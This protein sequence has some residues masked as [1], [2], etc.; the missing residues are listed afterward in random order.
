MLHEVIYSWTETSM[1]GKKMLAFGPVPSRRLGRSLGVNNVPFKTCSYSCI[2]CQLG[3]TEKI[4]KRRSFYDPEDLFS[5]VSERMQ[6]ARKMGERIDYATFVPDG[7]PTLDVNI[8]EEISLIR[9]T[10]VPVA[11]IT[12]A[13][14]LWLD[15][16]RQDL[17]NAD[18][19]CFKL[20]AVSE[21]AWRRVNRPCQKLRLDMIL[22]GI[23]RF[24]EVFKGKLLSET[25]I[26]EG[27][28]CGRYFRRMAAFLSRL[29][30]L[31]KAYV[32][33]PTRPPA[34]KW[35]RPASEEV[36]NNAFQVF[37][38]ELG[39]GRVECLMDYEGHTFSHTG[40]VRTDLLGI[41]SVHPMRLE[42]VKE[43]LQVAGVDWQV[44]TQ[45]LREN[46]IKCIEFGGK[47]Y[48][49]RKFSGKKKD[50]GDASNPCH[51]KVD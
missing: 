3:R 30:N 34:E 46:K 49:M 27:S 51:K 24:A 47:T 39:A 17:L 7:E 41:T 9:Q 12:N 11:V 15:S 25:M 33:V 40:D 2:Y 20:D 19:V 26:V 23:L 22:E 45:L 1:Q 31:F 8:G 18:L 6:A 44:I 13:S 43:F 21:E 28:D 42:A 10:G 50:E 35:V 4:A 14:L 37:E 38:K 48:Y 36:V 32:A 29:R 16:V 5:A